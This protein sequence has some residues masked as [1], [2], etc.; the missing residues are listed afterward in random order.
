MNR[1]IAT[2]IADKTLGKMGIGGDITQENVARSCKMMLPLINTGAVPLAVA[3]AQI[4]VDLP[5]EVVKLKAQG[6]S[7]DDIIEFYWS[8]PEFQKVWTRLKLNKDYL[9]NLVIGY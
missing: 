5:K 8:I 2:K 4:N 3:T 6:K 1:N 7:D 9:I